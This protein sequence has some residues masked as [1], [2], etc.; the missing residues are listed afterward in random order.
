MS[1]SEDHGSVRRLEVTGVRAP[2][3]RREPVPDGK[4]ELI[5]TYLEMRAP[6]ARQPSVHRSEKLA[7]MRAERPTVSFYRY[8]YNTVGGA[9]LWYERRLLDDEALRPCR[10]G[11][12]LEEQAVMRQSQV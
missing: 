2:G 9:W 6:P 12:L 8:L 5:V 1:S 10:P 11:R 7:L 3:Q 4:I